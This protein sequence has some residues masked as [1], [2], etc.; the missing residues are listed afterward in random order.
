M[1]FVQNE[2]GYTKNLIL[3]LKII[4]FTIIVKGDG[5]LITWKGTPTQRSSRVWKSNSSGSSDDYFLG[6]S[7][8]KQ[9]IGIYK[10]TSS[11]P[12]DRIWKERAGGSSPPSPTPRPPAPSP[13]G[14]PGGSGPRI[15]F[16]GSSYCKPSR[17]CSLCEGDCDV[18][19]L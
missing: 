17:R 19:G 4:T 6:L 13:N 9:Y 8:D 12:G 10:G 1:I 15:K 16:K 2:L 5:N 18:S 14:S 3:I 11:N 7:C